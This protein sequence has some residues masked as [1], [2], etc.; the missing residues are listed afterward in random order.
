MLRAQVELT[1]A[2]TDVQT[3]ALAIDTARAGL[4][5]LLSRS[6][7]DPLGVPEDAGLPEPPTTSDALIEAALAQRPE[8]AAQGATV[9]REQ[10]APRAGAQGLSAP[11]SS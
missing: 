5:A 1:H 10:H 4:N 9:A 7:G 11:T 8:L 6:P 3:G 2:A